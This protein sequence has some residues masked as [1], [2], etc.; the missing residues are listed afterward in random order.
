MPA[1]SINRRGFALADSDDLNEYTNTSCVHF[2]L[3]LRG[4]FEENNWAVMMHLMWDV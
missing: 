3:C 2:Q 1:H 4:E